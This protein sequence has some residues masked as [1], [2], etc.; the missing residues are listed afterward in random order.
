MSLCSC[1]VEHKCHRYCLDLIPGTCV[2]KPDYQRE[3]D[4][5]GISQ[6]DSPLL[7]R[8]G[9]CAQNQES[10][11]EREN[12]TEMGDGRRSRKYLAREQREKSRQSLCGL[13]T[14]GENLAERHLKKKK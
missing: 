3:D 12:E 4:G 11:K 9:A 2:V 13:N 5:L 10:K 1:C 8:K 6:C 14:K 7:F